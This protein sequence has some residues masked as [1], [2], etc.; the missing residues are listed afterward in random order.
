MYL[1]IVQQEHQ[2]NNININETIMSVI[3]NE[4]KAATSSSGKVDC[5]KECPCGVPAIVSTFKSAQWPPHLLN[6]NI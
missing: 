1:N 5:A 4:T 3:L 6:A 2:N